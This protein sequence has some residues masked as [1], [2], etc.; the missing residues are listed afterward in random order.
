MTRRLAAVLV[1]ALVLVSGAAVAVAAAPPKPPQPRD[2]V[3]PYY[4]SGQYTRDTVAVLRRATKALRRGL[5]HV[6]RGKKPAIVLDIDDT[7]L[8]QYPCRK[9]GDLAFNDGAQGVN[10]VLSAALPAID[11]TRALYDLAIKRHVRVFFITGRVPAM[12][13]ATVKN[14]RAEGYTTYAKLIL[15]P[16]SD[17]ASPSVI[18]FKSGERRKLVRAGY[19]ILV[20]VG[21]QDSDLAGGYADRSFKVPNPMYFIP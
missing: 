18:P 4:D 2:V 6:A 20:N 21:D 17:L 9:P 19:D 3:V 14:L 11:E 16:E 5:K 13:D 12:R 10:C 7:S 8:S 15:R 1:A